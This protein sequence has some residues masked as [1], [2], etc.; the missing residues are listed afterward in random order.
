MSSVSRDFEPRDRTNTAASQAIPLSPIVSPADRRG[1]TISHQS[2]SDAGARFRRPSRSNTVTT[3][4]QAERNE[5]N[6][7]P[8]AEP[9]LDTSAED[10]Q[11]PPEV[12]KLKARCEINIIDFSDSDVRHIFADN[13]S[14]PKIIQDPRPADM[15]CRWISINGLSWDVIKCLGRNVLR[16]LQSRAFYYTSAWVAE[17]A[18]AHA[19]TRRLISAIHSELVLYQVR[20]LLTIYRKHFQSSSIGDRGCCSHPLKDQS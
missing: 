2:A 13:E 3:Y 7:Q 16:V 14:L 15:P 11:L 19:V 17:A 6:W 4:H 8:G 10:H 5:P 9:G 12:S 20:H 1:S 18:S